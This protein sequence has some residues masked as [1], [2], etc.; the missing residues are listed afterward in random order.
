M[1]RRAFLPAAFQGV[2]F[3]SRLDSFWLFFRRN[4]ALEDVS[5]D[6]ACR[7]RLFY[8]RF[9]AIVIGSIGPNRRI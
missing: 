4:H 3:I 1:N 9:C 6:A 5:G 8:V 7:R 2:H